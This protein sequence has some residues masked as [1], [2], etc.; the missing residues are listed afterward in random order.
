LEQRKNNN[1]NNSSNKFLL[2]EHGKLYVKRLFDY[3]FFQKSSHI[4]VQFFRYFFVGGLAFVTDFAAL[5]FFTE[6][7]HF[8]YI[9]SNTLSFTIGLLVNYFLSIY[10]VFPNSAFKNKKVEFLLFILIAVIGLLLSDLLLWVLT[11]YCS[12]YY[13]WSKVIVS[14]IVWLWNFF[15]RKYFLFKN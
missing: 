7:C 13:L 15:A 12:L 10:W 11:L 2:F 9:I 8:Y 6:I 5:A 14:A 4:L 3:L 1:T